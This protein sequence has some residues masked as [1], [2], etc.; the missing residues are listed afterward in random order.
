MSYLD[1]VFRS[2]LN[3]DVLFDADV[4]LDFLFEDQFLLDLDLEHL[5]RPT[6]QL[7]NISYF[8]VITVIVRRNFFETCSDD[9]FREQSY[10]PVGTQIH[11]IRK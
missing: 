8:N 1:H 4:L 5:T 7:L 9:R 10:I 2:V 6:L 3:E 11:L